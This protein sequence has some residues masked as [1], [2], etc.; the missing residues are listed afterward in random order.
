MSG[1]FV[2]LQF[3]S[4]TSVNHSA[5]WNNESDWKQML[6]PFLHSCCFQ[7]FIPKHK[8]IH[9][10]FCLQIMSIFGYIKQFCTSLTSCLLCPLVSSWISRICL[11]APSVNYYWA[12]KDTFKF[13]K[14][15]WETRGKGVPILWRKKGAEWS[16]AKEVLH[17]HLTNWVRD[18]VW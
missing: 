18:E 3:V 10:T 7:L 4:L 9:T 6:P 8:K 1:S 13:K 16:H 17:W 5:P 15:L 14:K 12:Q 2:Q 11:N